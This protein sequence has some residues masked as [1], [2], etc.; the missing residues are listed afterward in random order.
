MCAVGYG[1]ML[2]PVV[3]VPAKQTTTVVEKKQKD[4]SVLLILTENQTLGQQVPDD[5][6][7]SS[8]HLYRAIA[9]LLALRIKE[10]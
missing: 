4:E 1:L 10:Y 5:H 3:A 9:F 8:P 6:P 2:L 7:C